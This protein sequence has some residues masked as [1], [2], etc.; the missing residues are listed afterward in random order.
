MG[1]ACSGL[2]L[3]GGELRPI[4][5][6]W[7]R[8]NRVSSK[9]TLPAGC[10]LSSQLI[11]DPLRAVTPP[12]Y[13]LYA[14]SFLL[15]AP[16]ILTMGKQRFWAFS[17]YGRLLFVLQPTD[18]TVSSL[19][20]LPFSH[21]TFILFYARCSTWFL[22]VDTSFCWWDCSPRTQASS[23]TIASPSLLICSVHH[24]ASGRCSQKPT[25]RE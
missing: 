6:V 13:P 7:R 15:L 11:P 3:T 12:D 2:R 18:F 16:L 10:N 8:L 5:R 14:D 17:P 20:D 21:G 19:R 22:V 9:Q 25:G 4:A 24:G 1:F 23:T